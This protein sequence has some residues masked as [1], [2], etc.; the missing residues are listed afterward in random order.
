MDMA[1]GFTAMEAQTQAQEKFRISNSHM[2]TR[3]GQVG[4][5][6]WHAPPRV[7]LQEARLE[8]KREGLGLGSQAELRRVPREGS[9]GSGRSSLSS[10]G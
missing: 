2:V 6:G 7:Q 4:R 1:F 10:A 8:G 9:S 3:Q 5:E